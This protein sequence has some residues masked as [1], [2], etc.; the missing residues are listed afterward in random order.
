MKKVAIVNGVARQVKYNQYLSKKYEEIGYITKEYKFNPLVLFSCH[1]H[2]TLD[3]TVQEIV[4]D[5]DVIHCQSGGYFPVLHYYVEKNHKKPF[6]FE[7]PVLRANTGTLL[8]GLSLS[9]S[10]ETAPDIKVV[11][12][13]LDALCFTPSWTAKTLAHLKDLKERKV[14]L[15]LA[16]KSDNVSDNRGQHDLLHHNFEKGKHARLF[17]D[18]DFVIVRDFLSSHPHPHH[19]QHHKHHHHEKK[20]NT[21]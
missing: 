6:I 14:S 19:H 7:T 18:N 13:M 3:S 12:M 5:H 21:R 17:Y 15:I 4:E 11:Q 2:K 8:A 10:Y 20:T 9:K 1:L 16:S